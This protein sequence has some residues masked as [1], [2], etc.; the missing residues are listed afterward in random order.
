MPGWADLVGTKVKGYSSFSTPVGNRS[1]KKAQCTWYCWNRASYQAGKKLSF[2]SSANAY[3]WLDAV[4][5]ANCQAIKGKIT[6]VRNSIAV[7]KG[8]SQGLGHLLYIEAVDNGRVYF[9]ESNYTKGRDGMYQTV[10][11]ADFLGE[12][13]TPH[14]EL[15]G[16]IIL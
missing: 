14:V 4:D 5:Q 15:L 10:K 6:P 16:Y 3:Q 9:S 8:G 11:T 1:F 13:R 12:W 7:Y 2:H